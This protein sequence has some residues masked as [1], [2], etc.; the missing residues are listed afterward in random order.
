MKEEYEMIK[1]TIFGE[2]IPIEDD[3]L[4]YTKIENKYLNLTSQYGE[5]YSN[6][7]EERI[8]SN[9]DFLES[10]SEIRNAAC[11]AVADAIVKSLIN[12]G[13]YD[14]NMEDYFKNYIFDIV[15]NSEWW[16]QTDIEIDDITE[17]VDEILDMQ[18]NAELKR[19]I[20]QM[21]AGRWSGGGFG[22]T[23]AIKGAVMASA[24]NA[25]SKTANSVSNAVKN[26]VTSLYSNKKIKAILNEEFFS[27]DLVSAFLC[28]VF[29]L[30]NAEIKFREER[31]GRKINIPSETNMAR[32]T[33]II[34]NISNMNLPEEECKKQIIS[35]LKLSPTN[36]IV[37]KFI[38]CRFG[39]SDRKIEDICKQL[40][41]ESIYVKCTDSNYPIRDEFTYKEGLL[42]E[43][44][45]EAVSSNVLDVPMLK[46]TIYE[47]GSFYGVEV[48]QNLTEL[49][50]ATENLIDKESR[51]YQN[52]V[53]KTKE[54]MEEAK[55]E[56]SVIID[57]IDKTDTENLEDLKK[58]KTKLSTSDF[59]QYNPKAYIKQVDEWITVAEKKLRTVDGIEYDTIE[60]ANEIIRQKKEIDS[61]ILKCNT[62]DDFINT[63]QY[64]KNIS[65]TKY[66]KEYG[67]DKLKKR[68]SSIFSEQIKIYKSNKDA[69]EAGDLKSVGC[70]V[71][72][73]IVIAI[74]AS[75]FFPIAG[76][77]AGI[78]L[79]I[80]LIV[81]AADRKKYKKY[82]QEINIVN[83]L[84][85]NGF[86]I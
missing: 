23:G 24:F 84:K 28:F 29:D 53:Y 65:Y 51:T 71:I 67:I 1:V 78:I 32:S 33:N 70:S 79:V 55:N 4:L 80:Y 19:K 74:I 15:Y 7:F 38:I 43:I 40:G 26:T 5:I 72:V 66:V 44:F 50:E 82:K 12:D 60:E 61:N 64:I 14:T 81:T 54:D 68:A 3:W 30:R 45:E 76:L 34:K 58:L 8:K 2:D 6:I 20:N 11:G 27:D 46:K 10:G 77:I 31:L 59:K 62:V 41:M 36:D 47:K 52:I 9:A 63:M 49:L 37:Y 69:V 17:R 42:Y 22:V 86:D 39:D 83:Q 85:N 25:V 75:I 56:E 57:L 21:S 35:A 16:K 48:P 13:Y 73:W 18:E